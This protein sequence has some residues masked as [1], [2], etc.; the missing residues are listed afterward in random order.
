MTEEAHMK[1]NGFVQIIILLSSTLKYYSSNLKI[2][3]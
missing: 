2:I 1:L 3:L